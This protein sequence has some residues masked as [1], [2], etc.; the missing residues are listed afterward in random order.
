M[1]HSRFLRRLPDPASAFIY[2]HVVMGGIAA[3]QTTQADDCIVFAGLGE[4]AGCR[5]NLKASRNAHDLDILIAR[6]GA[7][8]S[9]ERSLK[10][11]FRNEGV[12]A[13]DY[14][15]K[16]FAFSLELSLHA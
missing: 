5:G 1:G 14:D 16:A 10:K 4:H 7:A 9:I 3:Q 12:E 11:P 13:A 8:Q 6:A 2:D 15:C